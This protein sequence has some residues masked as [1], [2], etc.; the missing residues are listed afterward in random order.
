MRPVAA[1][2]CADTVW[3]MA[4]K[5]PRPRRV[6]VDEVWTMMQHEARFPV[7]VEHEQAS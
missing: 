5:D 1:L 3:A 4:T 2:V 6:V 7:Y